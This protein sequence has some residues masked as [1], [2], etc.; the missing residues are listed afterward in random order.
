RLY[1]RTFYNNVQTALTVNAGLNKTA[2][3]LEQFQ[4]VNKVTFDKTQATEILQLIFFKFKLTQ[5]IQLMIQIIQNIRQCIYRL[6]QITTTEML[7]TMSLGK[8]VQYHL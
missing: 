3:Q 2:F 6:F 4:I 5:Q 7:G 1:H 8:L